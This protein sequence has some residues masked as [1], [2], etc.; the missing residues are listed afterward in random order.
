VGSGWAYYNDVDPHACEWTKNLID[1]GLVTRGL[2]DTRSIVD[3]QARDLIGR[4][5]CHFF[6]G[7]CGWDLALQL[8]GW[9]D[10]W[11]VWTAS[12]PCHP[13][14]GA[15]K[16]AGIADERHL[17]PEMLRL[18][19][20][21]K[22]PA[23]FGEQVES[24][25][26]RQWLAGVRSDLESLG[27]RFGA[28]DLP[29]AC[30]GSPHRRQRLFWVGDSIRSGREGCRSGTGGRQRSCVG[31]QQVAQAGSWSNFDIISCR[32]GKQRRAES[33]VFP[34]AHGVPER[35]GRLRG[36]G[37]AI[38]PEVAAVFIHAFIETQEVRLF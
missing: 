2:V 18:I 5:R 27:Y 35:L 23:V 3:V 15:G 29:A 24:K 32:D 14:S 16:R 20:E 7:I 26:G 10:D 21:C 31:K 12:C 8:A 4:R 11:P 22:P 38:V 19:A 33:G 17:W 30:V 36:F 28:A 1:L 9:P 25:P 37:N 6:S 34:L 13:F